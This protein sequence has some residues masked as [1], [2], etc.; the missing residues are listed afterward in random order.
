MTK[1]VWKSIPGYEGLYQV[2]NFG[3]V[4]SLSRYAR[5]HNGVRKVGE[6]IRKPILKAT[7]Y[8]DVLLYK[9]GRRKR[10][11][12]H[13]LVAK[14]FLENPNNYKQINHK[15]ENPKN[16][17]L[18]NLE[19]CSQSYNNNYG[20]HNKKISASVPKKPVLQIADDGHVI[21]RFNSIK[22]AAHH[23]GVLEQNI[24]AVVRGIKKHSGGFPWKYA[25]KNVS[26]ANT[27]AQNK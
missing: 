15:D 23:V 21:Q 4:K 5:V 3:R 7:G 2:S 13:Q 26:A 18:S 17:H 24:S 6:R 11:L 1:E 9:D 10:F 16:N 19:W 20:N 12:V 8:Y 14:A 25:Q 22:D 27:D